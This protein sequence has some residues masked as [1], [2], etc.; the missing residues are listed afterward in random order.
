MNVD[1]LDVPVIAQPPVS[2]LLN[3]S[4]LAAG[5]EP[6]DTVMSDGA[7]IVG[8]AAGLT[9]IVL[10]TDAMHGRIDP[11]LSMSLLLFLRKHPEWL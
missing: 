7:V 10:D 2:P 8:K 9:V 3:G 11:S 6:H 4:V 5:I 1:R